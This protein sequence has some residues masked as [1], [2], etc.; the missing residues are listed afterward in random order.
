MV[1]DTEKTTCSYFVAT[2]S[3]LLFFN[4]KNDQTLDQ[5]A[6]RICGVS[7]L[8]AFENLTGHGPKQSAP[9]NPA[10]SRGIGLSSE[11]PSRLRASAIL[12]H[13]TRFQTSDLQTIQ[14]KKDINPLTLIVS[15][16]ET[17]INECQIFLALRKFNFSVKPK[18]KWQLRRKKWDQAELF[19]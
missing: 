17:V 14:Y 11:V 10:L 2:K 7:I 5:A 9:V 4:W 3:F 8:G 1:S 19:N 15:L 12:W 18:G 16:N 13:Q 6:K